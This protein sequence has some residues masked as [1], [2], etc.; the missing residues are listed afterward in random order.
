MLRGEK[1]QAYSVEELVER[2]K[3]EPVPA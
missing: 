3:E 1:N 2:L